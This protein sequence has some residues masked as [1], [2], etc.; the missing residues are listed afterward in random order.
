MLIRMGNARLVDATTEVRAT[1]A[2]HAQKL[3]LPEILR[4]IRVFN[5]AA[6]EARNNWQPSLPLEVA[7][8]EAIQPASTETQPDEQTQPAATGKQTTPGT[9]TPAQKPEQAAETGEDGLTLQMIQNNW[10]TILSLVRR[11]SPNAEGLLRSGKILGIKD[12]VLYLGYSDVLKS[13]ME[14]SENI[15]VLTQ[16][17]QEA[18]KMEVPIR[19]VTFTGKGNAIPAGIDSDG[20]VAT[21]LRDLGGEIVDIQ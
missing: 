4:L 12:G 2:Q 7:L 17:F 11:R 13:K 3:S 6:N 10:Q 8:V 9:T 20:M 15:E 5:Q 21:V 19:C 1:A 16:A 18:L 14:K